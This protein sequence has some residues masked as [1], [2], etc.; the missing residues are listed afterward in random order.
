MS[1][2]TIVLALVLNLSVIWGAE[3]LQ[4]FTWRLGAVQGT[5]APFEFLVGFQGDIP[6][7]QFFRIII[8]SQTGT[9]VVEEPYVQSISKAPESRLEKEPDRSSAVQ[10]EFK[11]NASRPLPRY[12]SG[13]DTM[14]L[15]NIKT[16]VANPQH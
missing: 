14:V 7:P 5:E 13:V 12:L 16:V 6:T 10:P 2:L 3:N 4:A 9:A 15:R 11:R 8:D 1:R